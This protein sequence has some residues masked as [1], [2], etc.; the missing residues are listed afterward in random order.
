MTAP[1]ATPAN[2]TAAAKKA[3]ATVTQLD[4][5]KTT[6]KDA[7]KATHPSSAAKGAPAPAEKAEKPAPAGKVLPTAPG[8]LTWAPKSEADPREHA[9][10]VKYTYRLT[11]GSDG[12]WFAALRTTSGGKW[13]NVAGKCSTVDEAKM[14][15]G[16]VEA[17]AMW[18]TYSKLQGVPFADV[19]ANHSPIAT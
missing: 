8:E 17:G 4:T 12:G 1:K 16:W 7:A 19:I 10:G 14:L 3:P 18:L 2:T 11:E 13:V 9:V 15:C 5:A 6:A